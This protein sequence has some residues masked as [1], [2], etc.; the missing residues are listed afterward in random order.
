MTDKE[1]L[2]MV[3]EQLFIEGEKKWK[4]GGTNNQIYGL[5]ILYAVR[6]IKK[7]MKDG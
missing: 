3:L 2:E 1:K 6:T 7:A 4:E 5:G